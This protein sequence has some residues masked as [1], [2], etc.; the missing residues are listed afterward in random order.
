MK[1]YFQKINK[2]NVVEEQEFEKIAVL[3]RA[4]MPAEP[5][6][7][8][9]HIILGSLSETIQAEA[10]KNADAAMPTPYFEKS[11]SSNFWKTLRDTA[12]LG[13]VA[14]I[15]LL[16]TAIGFRSSPQGNGLQPAAPMAIN[17]TPAENAITPEPKNVKDVANTIYSATV[18]KNAATVRSARVANDKALA[19][20]DKETIHNLATNYDDAF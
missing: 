18:K 15:V 13:T 17:V 12:P 9:L 10:A 6:R 1:K 4:S 3:L 16:V 14:A 7:E 11:F 8:N 20:N 2:S 19:L 5:S